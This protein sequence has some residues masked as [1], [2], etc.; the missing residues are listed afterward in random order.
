M[1]IA[2]IKIIK[3]IDKIEAWRKNIASLQLTKTLRVALLALLHQL[4]VE[5]WLIRPSWYDGH[6]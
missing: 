4:A 6:L 2:P 1:A 3:G 5:I